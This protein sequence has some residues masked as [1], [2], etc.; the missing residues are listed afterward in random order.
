MPPDATPGLITALKALGG[1]FPTVNVLVQPGTITELT[2]ASP[3]TLA[4]KLVLS[5]Y[6]KVGLSDVRLIRASQLLRGLVV[7]VE[8]SSGGM[9]LAG[10]IA[11]YSALD[12]HYVLTFTDRA[13]ALPSHEQL[14]REISE[15]FTYKGQST[16]GGFKKPAPTRTSVFFEA[17]LALGLVLLL[18]LI[19]HARSRTAPRS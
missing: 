9:K 1:G 13:D 19:L 6:R 18:G 8:Y 14:F 7:Q 4:E 12:R 10:L 3:A 5:D 16:D 11:I 17:L 15:S 2:S